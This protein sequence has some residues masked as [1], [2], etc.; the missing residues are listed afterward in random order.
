[1]FPKNIIIYRVNRDI[2]FDPATLE[3]QLDEFKLTPCGSQD[4][5]KFGWV[6]ALPACGMFTHVSGGHILIRAG[7]QEKI[8]PA[9]CIMKLVN[10]RVAVMEAEEGRPLR[11][12]EKDDIRDDI[13]M[14]KLPTAFIKE[15]FTN[16]FIF[17]VDGLIV[18]DTSTHKKAEDTLALLRKSMGSLPCI[19]LIPQI[20]V[21]TT[22]T[23]WVKTGD[24]P[25]GYEIGN[26][27]DMKSIL[28]DGGTVKLKNNELTS[29]AVHQH[30]EEDKMVIALELSW[31]DRISFVLKENMQ[32]SRVNFGD[33]ITDQNEDI[34]RE[35]VHARMD[36][37]F[38]LAAG[39]MLA[40]IN[41]LINVLGG[42]DEEMIKHEQ[43]E[44]SLLNDAIAFVKE[45]RRASVSVLQR[46]FKIGFNHAA[47]IME[48]MEEM[49]IVSKPAN[50]GNREVLAPP[51]A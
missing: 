51:I 16:V 40:L 34:P 13:V 5:Q 48:R 18:V 1:M 45:T 2:K 42:L 43:R 39:E 25:S 44:D 41:S 8:L 26:A 6:S 28:D 46:K 33:V 37:D 30:I 32:L 47:R 7:K 35:E 49:N 3:Q 11:K 17:P 36:A 38:A 29:D 50:N 15:T 9:S 20:A 22:L 19:P 21:E 14:D 27:A 23:E 12:A 24:V 10:E 31:Q 4:K